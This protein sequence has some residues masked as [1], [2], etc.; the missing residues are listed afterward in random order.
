MVPALEKL[1]VGVGRGRQLITDYTTQSAESCGRSMPK[2][3]WNLEWVALHKVWGT[4][5]KLPEEG[6]TWADP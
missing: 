4:E 5:K 2:G 6:G 3:L 1:E